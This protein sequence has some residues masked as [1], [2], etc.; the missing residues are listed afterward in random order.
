MRAKHVLGTAPLVV[1]VGSCGGGSGVGNAMVAPPEPAP[2]TSVSQVRVSQDE[3][4]T[5][6]NATAQTG[7]LYPNTALEP[8]LIVN[9]TNT[10]NLIAEWQETAGTAAGPRR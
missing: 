7:T 3:T 5:N 6:C 10:A 9:P 1:L 2:F 8:S 4:F